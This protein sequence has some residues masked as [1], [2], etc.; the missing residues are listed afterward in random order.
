M[1]PPLL[2]LL[3]GARQLDRPTGLKQGCISCCSRGCRKR[4]VVGGG[5]AA[6]APQLLTPPVLRLRRLLHVHRHL[7]LL[8]LAVVDT[9]RQARRLGSLQARTLPA[10]PLH[11]SEL[12]QGHI[13]LAVHAP[14]LPRACDRLP[15]CGRP[16]SLPL[17]AIQVLQ[18]AIIRQPLHICVIPLCLGRDRSGRAGSRPSTT[19]PLGHTGLGGAVGWPLCRAGCGRLS[20]LLL[21][22]LHS[23]QS[24]RYVRTSANVRAPLH[25]PPAIC[26]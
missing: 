21:P 9:A 18:I 4:P 1:L 24:R 19:P 8:L 14:L 17:P 20:W 16:C 10:L 2:P 23:S 15:A 6:A 12:P 13:L 25:C 3:G 7:C 22:G 26:A 5:N 11:G